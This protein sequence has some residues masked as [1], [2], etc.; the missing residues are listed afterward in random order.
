MLKNYRKDLPIFQFHS[1]QKFSDEVDHAVLSRQGGVSQKPFD[2][3]NVS[4]TVDD[5]A[6][7][8]LKNRSM[9]CGAFDISEERLIAANQVHGK[10]VM[11]IDDAIARNHQSH[12]DVDDVDAFVTNIPGVALMMKVADCQ[13]LLMFDPAQKVVAAVHAGWR[14][15]MQDISGETIN[16]LKKDFGVKPE[17]LIVGIGPSLGPCCSFF[18]DPRVELSGEFEPYID[19]KNKVDLWK[20]STDQLVKHG[21][22]PDHIEHARVCSMCGAGDKFYSFRRDRGVTG[23]FGVLIL[24]R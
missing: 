3:L 2:S 17:N 7:D 22:K 6:D 12:R 5:S 10:K 24:L 19:G 15:L 16:V 4:L 13:A 11:V 14:G 8:V 23:R 1:L 21:I 18:S 20:F 9:I